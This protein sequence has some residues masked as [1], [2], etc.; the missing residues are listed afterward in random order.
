MA[1]RKICGE[2]FDGIFVDTALPNFSKQGYTR[3]IRKSRF[4][5]QAP[6]VLLSGFERG[7]LEAKTSATAFR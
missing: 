2:R 4:N 7:R 6:V 1:A 5:T 3:L